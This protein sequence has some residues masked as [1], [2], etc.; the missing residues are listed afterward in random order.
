MKSKFFDEQELKSKL[1]SILQEIHDNADPE[2]LNQYRTFFKKNVSIFRRGY[3]AGYLLK[4]LSA[5]G[6]G[7]SRNRFRNQRVENR[8]ESRDSKPRLAPEVAT[9]LF[10]GIG[11][12]RRVYPRDIMGLVLDI[13]KVEREHIGAIKILDNYS[14][15]DVHQDVAETIIEAV[16][17]REY[18]GRTLNVNHAKKKED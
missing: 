17:G 15:V 8:S 11:K 1:D 5:N 6:G 7:S 9:T 13:E 2:E 10:F 4:V 3:V 18:R 14:F 16:N 12:S